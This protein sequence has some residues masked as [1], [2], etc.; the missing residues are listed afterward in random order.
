[1][2]R[3]LVALLALVAS[4]ALAQGDLTVNGQGRGAQL[5]AG[6]EQTLARSPNDIEALVNLGMAYRAL[7]REGDARAMLTRVVALDNTVLQDRVGTDVWSRS[8]AR[9]ALRNPGARP[10]TVAAR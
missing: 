3:S 1:M 10:V 2:G 5:V 6:W 4:P 7:G 8:L 9:D